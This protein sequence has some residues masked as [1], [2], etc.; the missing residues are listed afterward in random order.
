METG[1]REEAAVKKIM[2]ILRMKM[3]II[4]TRTHTY[5]YAQTYINRYIHT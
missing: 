3:I 2:M 1:G 5:R 4:Y